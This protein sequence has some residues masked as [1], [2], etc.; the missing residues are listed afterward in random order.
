MRI[1]LLRMPHRRGAKPVGI[2]LPGAGGFEMVS[3]DG[4]IDGVLARLE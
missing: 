3:A 2:A 4:R 1:T